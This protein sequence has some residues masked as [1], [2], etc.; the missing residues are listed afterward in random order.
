MAPI[1]YMM[2]KLVVEMYG[3]QSLAC[4]LHQV[5]TDLPASLANLQSRYSAKNEQPAL[6][7]SDPLGPRV[8]LGT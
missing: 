1:Y 8:A 4:F 2:V 6:V 3:N 5:L 7:G